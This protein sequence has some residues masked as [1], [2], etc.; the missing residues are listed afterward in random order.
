MHLLQSQL[1]LLVVSGAVGL[2][3]LLLGWLLDA[4][5]GAFE[6]GVARTCG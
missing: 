6:R 3:L 2:G 5:I 1:C 4:G